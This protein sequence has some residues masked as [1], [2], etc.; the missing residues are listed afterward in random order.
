MADGTGGLL[1]IDVS[2]PGAMREVARYREDCVPVDVIV[3]GDYA[4]VLEYRTLLRVFDIHDPTALTVV[5]EVE[6]GVILY[7]LSV[8]ENRAYVARGA[9]GLT[10]VDI[11]D[12]TAPSVEGH[13]GTA[14]FDVAARG[15]TAYVASWVSVQVLNLSNPSSVVEIGSHPICCS[16]GLALQGDRLFVANPESLQVLDV[17]DPSEPRMIGYA[18]SPLAWSGRVV[19][20]G[21]LVYVAKYNEGVWILDV[22]SPEDPLALALYRVP[23]GI[24]DT[25]VRGEL[26][27]LAGPYHGLL[28]LDLSDPTRPTPLGRLRTELR[29]RSLDVYRN[30]AFLT[31]DSLGLV[32]VDVS[33]PAFPALVGSLDLDDQVGLVNVDQGYAVVAALSGLHVVDVRNPAAPVETGVLPTTRT[34]FTDV[35]TRWPYVYVTG[36]SLGFGIVD[37]SDPTAPVGVAFEDE[38]YPTAVFPKDGLAY[39][40]RVNRPA[41]IWDVQPPTTPALVGSLGTRANVYYDVFASH[42]RAILANSWGSIDVFDVSDLAAP[43]RAGHFRIDGSPGH[44]SVLGQLIFEGNGTSGFYV[45]RDDLYPVPPA[46]ENKLRA[47]D[48]DNNAW[49]GK[50]VAIDGNVAVIGAPFDDSEN[51]VDAGAVYVF[52]R[53]ASGRWEFERKLVADDGAPEDLFGYSVSL[54]EGRLAVGACWDDDAGEKSGAVYI[55]KMD[56]SGRWTQEAK[57]V[58]EDAGEDARFG[59]SVALDQHTLLVGAF[60]DDDLGRRSGSAYVFTF[61]GTAWNQQAKLLASDGAEG[62]WFGVSV[63]LDGDLAAVGARYDDNEN[64][65]DA[66]AVY[67]FRRSGAS[68][69]ETHKL[70]P[71]D[72][73]ARERFHAVA[74]RGDWLVVGAP[75]DDDNGV[76]SGSAYLFHHEGDEWRQDT[77]LLPGDGA[78]YQ[79]FGSSVAVFGDVL[80]VGAPLDNEGAVYGGA[81]YLYEF[82]GTNWNATRKLLPYDPDREADFGLSVALDGQNLLVGA[83]RDDDAGEE[84][85]AAYIFSLGRETATLHVPRDYPTI[86]AAMAAADYG[87]TVLVALGTYEESVTMRPGV[88][89]LSESGPLRTQIVG[90]GVDQLVLGAQDAVIDGFTIAGND[91]GE[92]AAGSGVFSDGDNFTISHCI[93][94]DNRGG[95]YL[96]NGSHAVVRNNTIYGNSFVGIYMQIEPAPRITNNI[97]AGNG[98]YGILRN[99]AHSLGHPFMQYNC[100]FGNGTDF[101]SVGSNWSPEPGTGQVTQDPLFVGGSP[102]DFSLVEESP[103]VDAGDPASPSDPDGTPADLGAVPYW[104][105]SGGSGAVFIYGDES[106]ASAYK[107]FLYSIGLTTATIP[108]DRAAQSDLSPYELIIVGPNTT[109]H[110]FEWEGSE[111]LEAVVSANKPILGLGEGGYGFFGALRLVIGFPWGAHGFDTR[112][113]VRLV[114][115]ALFRSPNAIS[116][117]ADSVL[118]LYGNPVGYVG[119]YLSEELPALMPFTQVDEAGANLRYHATLVRDQRRYFLWGYGGTP[120]GMTETGKAL[121]ANVVASLATLSPSAVSSFAGA[122]LPKEFRLYQNSPNPFNPS[123][124]IRYDLPGDAFVELTVHDALGREIRSLVSGPRNAGRHSVVWDGRDN[125]GRSVGSGAYLYRVRVVSGGRTRQFTG[126]MVLMK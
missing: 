29:P 12:P 53:N 65:E 54:N 2:N 124:V 25:V 18:I 58:A 120:D 74:L 114:D 47:P 108:V 17:S 91:N 52:R 39:L 35:E 89:L 94:R 61:D 62:D 66:G 36:V 23:G 77:K 30:F 118:V 38:Y 75:Y 98:E 49:F 71:D 26:A 42:D 64:G 107:L 51:G 67:L 92:G 55:F 43:A 76:Q 9:G 104:Q 13:L 110:D 68:W 83:R 3:R 45:L 81:V 16:R 37:I 113:K 46:G 97:I 82:D 1:V 102:F 109:A 93:I 116:I 15:D 88:A 57:V 7:R 117:P 123:T 115:N 100:Y 72:G 60:F 119:I 105:A 10:I 103:C 111:A 90:N 126:K 84:A 80:C 106:I 24:L 69:N 70:L 56:H 11:S 20:S 33:D 22:S 21:E 14:V 96:N 63:A 112:A 28:I 87:D 34:S 95:I 79:R 19:V 27:Y 32:V 73:A 4:Y 41:H 122:G 78:E 6:V 86:S 99:T 5:G 40:S 8:A 85:G 44:V 121:L 125:A 31:Q 50:D 59:I 48:G 101:G